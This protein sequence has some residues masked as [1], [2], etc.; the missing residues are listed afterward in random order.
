MSH[1]LDDK[2]QRTKPHSIVYTIAGGAIDYDNGDPT[3]PDRKTVWARAAGNVA[4]TIRNND[5]DPYEVRIPFA[6]FAPKDGG[7]S[8]PINER[9][10]GNDSVRVAPGG[11]EMLNYVIKPAAYFPFSPST[12]AFT[13]KYT[14]YYANSS[15]GIR[16]VVD[17]DLEVSP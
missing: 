12:P 14:L 4:F 7:P 13:Y 1:V 9:A 8:G 3:A 10:S 6:E 11:V 5:S 15:A 2:I 16:T 17:P